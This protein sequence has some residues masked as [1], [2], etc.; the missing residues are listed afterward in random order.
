MDIMGD[1][2]SEIIELDWLN[3][4]YSAIQGKPDTIENVLCFRNLNY[5]PFF[6]NKFDI[7]IEK[8]GI[9]KPKE[10]TPDF[11]LW[12]EK[13]E[14]VI[15]VEVKGENS[16]ERKNLDQ[17]NKYKKISIQEV[18]NRLRNAT[19]NSLITI[20]NIYTGIVYRKK[21][22]LNC[23]LS[24]DCKTLLSE[25][26]E[27]NLVFTQNHGERLEI[28]NNQ[29]ITFD[30][31]LRKTLKNGLDLPLNPLTIFYLTK[32]PC[33]KG[34][35]WAIVNHIHNSFYNTEKIEE[36]RITPISL[37]RDVFFY[38]DVK[39]NQIIEALENLFHLRI[40]IRTDREY[41]F[42][43]NNIRDFDKIKEKINN[44]DCKQQAPIQRDLIRFIREGGPK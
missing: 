39:L 33:K 13:K 41:I 38:S 23:K 5:K 14:L 16:V 17:L 15:I 22:I 11:I 27:N 37:R 10:V 32:N 42:E 30:D 20:K 24:E 19:D 12:N 6:F 34:I 31:S 28:L 1:L 21:T 26:K 43:F 8:D 3:L 29:L 7:I 36:I 40:C 18:Q 2:T 9:E 35:I 4:F 25:I 44:I